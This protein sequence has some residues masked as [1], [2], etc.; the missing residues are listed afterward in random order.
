M[1]L[2]PRRV[3]AVLAIV[4]VGGLIATTA[5]AAIPSQTGTF[6][7]CVSNLTGVLRVIDQSQGQS[8]RP[9]IE[10]QIQWNQTGV[11]GPPGP[12]GPAGSPALITPTGLT[13]LDQLAGLPCTTSANETGTTTIGIQPAVDGG[14]I[15]LHCDTGVVF[16]RL[17]GHLEDPGNGLA[18]S[19][20][21]RA[22][23]PGT[24]CDFNVSNG[25]PY[26]WLRYSRADNALVTLTA[27]P[28]DHSSFGAWEDE[29]AQETSTTCTIRMDRNRIVGARFD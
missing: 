9:R 28:G 26:C 7:G 20:H 22:D 18:S 12:P 6:N 4:A 27:I 1:Q 24:V 8:C 23:P 17:G 19:G 3:L 15:N 13:S 14:A 10:T 11:Q 25:N 29:C 16:L 2:S 21:I 5:Y